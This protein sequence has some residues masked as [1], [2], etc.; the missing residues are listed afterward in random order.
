MFVIIA[1]II[2]SIDHMVKR[3]PFSWVSAQEPIS[4]A[5]TIF[6]NMPVAYWQ[7]LAYYWHI[8]ICQCSRIKKQ[9]ILLLLL[10]WQSI[11]EQKKIKWMIALWK[12]ESD[13]VWHLGDFRKKIIRKLIIEL[14]HTQNKVIII[15]NLEFELAFS[16]TSTAC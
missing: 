10:Q 12:V 13:K 16:L 6:V 14:F 2:F 3:L 1:V 7:R 5:R 11:P 15:H 4:Y 8:T 9:L